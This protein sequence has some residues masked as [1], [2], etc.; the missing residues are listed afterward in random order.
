MRGVLAAAGVAAVV[1]VVAAAAPTGP[2]TSEAA[3]TQASERALTKNQKVAFIALDAHKSAIKRFST[4]VSQRAAV[5]NTLRGRIQCL[6]DRIV[7]GG[8]YFADY[9]ALP[10][11][12]QMAVAVAAQLTYWYGYLYKAMPRRGKYSAGAIKGIYLSA[13]KRARKLNPDI[14]GERIIRGLQAQVDRINAY[15]KFPSLQACAVIDDWGMNGY[16]L[17][18]LDPFIDAYSV[19]GVIVTGADYQDRFSLAIVSMKAV[20]GIEDSEANDFSDEIVYDVFSAIAETI[21]N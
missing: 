10:S 4:F 7:T 3:G 6:V 2:A 9:D 12:T 15:R 8:T 16:D 14:T 20:P 17:P 1:T 18:R 5:R 13:A 21:V 19:L 11:G